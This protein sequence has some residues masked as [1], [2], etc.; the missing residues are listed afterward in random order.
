M[1]PASL[2]CLLARERLAAPSSFWRPL[3]SSQLHYSSLTSPVSS[4]LGAEPEL[5]AAGGA[6][7]RGAL[8]EVECASSQATRPAGSMLEELHLP[9][10]WNIR[11]GAMVCLEKWD[12]S[13]APSI[14]ALAGEVHDSCHLHI[15]VLFFLGKLSS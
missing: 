4:Q 3:L 9:L 7:Q 8:A 13:V 12:F 14:D 2:P 5:A 6:G 10:S 1:L 11:E 15:T